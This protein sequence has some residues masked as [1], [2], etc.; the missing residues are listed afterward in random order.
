ML[1]FS[2]CNS[3]LEFMIKQTPKKKVK[4]QALVSSG[5]LLGQTLM[6]RDVLV[7]LVFRFWSLS[8]AAQKKI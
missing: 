6:A 1:W 8:E 3:D 4:Q 2:V 5:L 7:L